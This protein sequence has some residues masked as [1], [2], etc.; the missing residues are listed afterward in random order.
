LQRHTPNNNHAFVC[1]ALQDYLNALAKVVSPNAA[2][3]T[4]FRRMVHPSRR[5]ERADT[6]DAAEPLTTANMIRRVQVGSFA[7]A[8]AA[9]CAW[10][11]YKLAACIRTCVDLT[12]L[13]CTAWHGPTE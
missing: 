1:C 10:M 8:V 9:Q 7:G 4:N 11:P 5:L 12:L 6:L 2:S 13:H 3:I